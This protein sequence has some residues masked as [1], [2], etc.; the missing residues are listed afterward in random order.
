MGIT[1]IFKER[2]APLMFKDTEKEFHSVQCEGDWVEIR[3]W[4][5]NDPAA[6]GAQIFPGSSVSQILVG[7]IADEFEV[8]LKEKKKSWGIKVLDNKENLS[9][10]KGKLAIAVETLDA[11]NAEL[12]KTKKE[13]NEV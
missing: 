7:V 11:E 3:K 6:I 9:K 12:L 2:K 10:K 4:K 13:E 8:D 5:V 1:I